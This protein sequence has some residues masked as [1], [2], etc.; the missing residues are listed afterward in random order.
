MSSWAHTREREG[1]IR[2]SNYIKNVT[3]QSY[4]CDPLEIVLR[5]TRNKT[6]LE[7]LYIL[8]LQCAFGGLWRWDSISDSETL[9]L[10]SQR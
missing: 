2:S 10:S 6:L 3:F 5:T 1:E 8:F 9:D 7:E 4:I